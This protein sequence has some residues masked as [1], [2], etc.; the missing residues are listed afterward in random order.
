MVKGWQESLHCLQK[1]RWTLG[2]H[3][4]AQASTLNFLC[5]RQTNNKSMESDLARHTVKTLKLLAVQRHIRG[6][7]RRRKGEL[8]SMI[9]QND[10]AIC[11]QRRYRRRG[12]RVCNTS[13][14]ITLEPLGDIGACFCYTTHNGERIAYTP[15]TLA[16][17]IIE[18]GRRC[19][20]VT[21]EEYSDSDIMRLQN[22][23]PQIQTKIMSKIKANRSRAEREHATTNEIVDAL[24]SDLLRTIRDNSREQSSLDEILFFIF[25]A[26]VPSYFTLIS[27]MIDEGNFED[28]RSSHAQ[29]MQSIEDEMSQRNNPSLEECLRGVHRAL[30]YH[31][32]V[33]ME[34]TRAE[35]EQHLRA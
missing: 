21:R 16:N 2:A 7:S 11:I 29:L 32:E 20:P 19:D 9:I 31:T 17:Y 27:I 28:A 33:S 18:S 4:S 3:A 30:A 15:E 12:P 5:V 24:I 22:Q 10:A 23:V 13:D 26:W 35:E 8:I 1:S 25:I 14:P 6:I 34:R